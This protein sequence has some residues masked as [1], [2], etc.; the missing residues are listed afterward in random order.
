MVKDKRPNILVIMTDQQ[1]AAAMSCT[2]NPNLRTPA[3]DSLS[4]GGMRFEKAYSC[5]PICVPSRT[6]MFTGLMCHQTQV[7]HNDAKGIAAG[8]C[9]GKC[10]KDAG[11][12]TGYTGKWHIP[13]KLQD[14]EWSGF[15][16]LSA[17]G[18][19]R[20]DEAIPGACGQFFKIRRDRPFF[21]VAS[22]LNP[23]D[24]C[25]FARRLSGIK[26]ELMEGE[27]GEPPPVELCPPLPP[28]FET[29]SDEP[30]AIRI[31][32]QHSKNWERVYPTRNWDEASWRR[33]LWGYSRLVEKVDTQVGKVLA[34][35][36]EN[37]LEQ[38]TVVI[39]T[40]D[41]GDGMA[42]HRWNQKTI[43]YEEVARV[44]FIISQ[45]GTIAGGVV[46]TRILINTGI[47][48]ATTCL[49]IA[50]V[51][52]PAEL[53][54]QDLYA[55]VQGKTSNTHPFIVAQTDLLKAPDCDRHIRGRMLRTDKFKYVVFDHGANPEQLFNLETDQGEM[56]NLAYR[57]EEAATLAA[58]RQML[59][60]WLKENGDDFI[61]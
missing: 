21:L 32:K 31:H 53:K 60:N 42:S 55:Y 7:E 54:G 4:A 51:P 24:T 15:D 30:E 48:L 29:P 27:I 40:S 2:G 26:E 57:T 11:Y 49:G 33:Y 22:F 3:M 14:Q 5:N 34:T 36:R 45:P 46:D 18:N 25:Q 38:D 10:L 58:H 35:L 41:H 43:F 50:G 1:S 13:H 19:H 47:D 16:F 23:H 12:D 39:F 17:T 6:S 56:H 59:E 61:K 44:P 28:N 37:G 20:I 8:I 52:V 9:L